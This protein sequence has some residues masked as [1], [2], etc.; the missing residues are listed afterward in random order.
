M[1]AQTGYLDVAGFALRS[2]MPAES[3]ARLENKSPGWLQ[4]KLNEKS[5]WINAQLPKRYDA[6]FSAP[7]PEIVLGWL[8]AIVTVE[9]YGRLG[10]NIT[11]EQDKAFILD[12]DA[13]ARQEIKEACDAVNGLFDLPLRANTTTSGIT[14]GGPLGY[15]EQSPY[16]AFD[17]Q[18]AVARREDEARNGS[19]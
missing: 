6:P 7:Y 11:Q 17:R 1:V 3:I 5:G 12:P 19:R 2:I 15:S 14:R 9:A 8:V 13:R 16:V 18:S 10:V 4:T